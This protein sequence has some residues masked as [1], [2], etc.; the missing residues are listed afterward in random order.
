MEDKDR[1]KTLDDVEKKYAGLDDACSEIFVT[2]LAYKRL[3]FNP[4]LATLKKLGMKI[5]QPTL[6]DHLDHLLEKGLIDCKRGFQSASYG[7][8]DKIA[9]LMDV[10][11]EDLKNWV[12]LH[13]DRAD[14]PE[15]LKPLKLSRKELLERFSEEQLEKMV[16]NDLNDTIG[17]NLF[18]LKTFI[19]YELKGDKFKSNA[20][21][22]KF[23]GN[24]MYRM[25]ERT[26]AENCRDSERYRRLLFE[27]IDVL[28]DEL[29]SDKELLRKRKETAFR[30]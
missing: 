4:L 6:K 28:V 12:E 15:I 19:D 1:E 8:T 7:L 26:V 9:S 11:E 13:R 3:R 10:S 17:L 23:V 21:F 27:K 29:R 14:L 20:D 30:K 18:E 24:P 22:W 16:I 2:L 25:H 5:T